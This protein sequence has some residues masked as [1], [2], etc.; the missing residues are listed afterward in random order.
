[1]VNSKDRV[2]LIHKLIDHLI[3]G[4]YFR[5]CVNCAEW[6]EKENICGLYNRLPPP[7]VIVT[8]CLHHSDIIPF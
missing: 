4:G 5:N 2:G 1:M 7:N 8:G 6:K 3:D